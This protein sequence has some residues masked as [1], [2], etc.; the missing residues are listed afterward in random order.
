VKEEEGGGGKSAEG[1]MKDAPEARRGEGGG[2]G[3][4]PERRRG[5]NS[6]L[7]SVLSSVFG[8]FFSDGTQFFKCVFNFEVLIFLLKQKHYCTIFV[9]FLNPPLSLSL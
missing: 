4:A 2:G 9:Q 8:C 5:S 6:A 1:A 7:M 3:E